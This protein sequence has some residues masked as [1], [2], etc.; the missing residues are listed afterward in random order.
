MR[1]AG[2]GVHGPLAIGRDQD[3]AAPGRRP[4]D[5]RRRFEAHAKRAHVVGEDGA[6]LVLGDLPD[7]RDAGPACGSA[8]H[9]VRRR[10]AA[11]LA[12]A[13][14]RVV[15]HQRL[16]RIEQLH[17]ALGQVEA[18]QE[19]VV[20]GRDDVDQRVAHGEDVGGVGRG[21]HEGGRLR[22]RAGG[23]NLAAAHPVCP[24]SAPFAR[25]RSASIVTSSATLPS[26][27]AWR[28]PCTF[29]TRISS[30]VG[31]CANSAITSS[32]KSSSG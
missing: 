17:R 25:D 19:V 10:A 31:C 5:Q 8:R 29:L 22:T 1:G 12:R 30:G 16:G 2:R 32:A 24:H 7:E 3:Q 20:A 28:K 14:H 9:A 18:S 15:Q 13:A 21:G 27:S 11:R 23:V 4:V 6:E 26:R